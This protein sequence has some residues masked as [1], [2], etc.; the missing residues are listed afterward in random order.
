MNH[1]I[2]VRQIT[3]RQSIARNCIGYDPSSVLCYRSL[4]ENPKVIQLYAEIKSV[5]IMTHW[6]LSF[7]SMDSKLM[8]KLARQAQ[9]LQTLLKVI[10]VGWSE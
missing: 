2:S 6:F 1:S 7:L 5:L 4:S 8:A 3:A 10:G 9:M